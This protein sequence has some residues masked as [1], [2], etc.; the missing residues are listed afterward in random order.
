MERKLPYSSEAEEALIACLLIE[1]ELI[2][3]IDLRPEDFFG[4]KNQKIFRAI[5]D[6]KN[7]GITADQ[8]MVVDRL[9]ANGDY[10]SVGGIEFFAD[11]LLNVPFE[12]NIK[13]YEKVI[14]DNSLKRSL[15][16]TAS[17]I[18][19][20]CYSKKTTAEEAIAEAEKKIFEVSGLK[21]SD[22]TETENIGDVMYK[23][24]E[25]IYENS[26]NGNEITGLSTGFKKLDFK[27]SGLQRSDLII[28]AA[29]PSMGKTALAVNIAV[30]NALKENKSV[31]IFSL[32]MSKE[33]MALRMLQSEAMISAGKLKNGNIA[34]EDW[35]PIHHI[36]KELSKSHIKICDKA[37][38]SLSELVNRARKE[39]LKGDIDLIVID[40]LQLM[41]TDRKENR[42]SEISE[43]SRGLKQLA[44]EMDCPV[45]CLSQ[46]S[47]A[48]ETRFDKHPV[49]SD[50]R[51]SGSIE[52]DADVVLM[53][54]RASYYDEEKSDYQAELNIAKQRNGPTGTI[55]LGWIP[56]YTKFTETE[57]E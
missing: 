57:L 25:K 18:L 23:T 8:A 10:K 3:E 24:V 22:Q 40:Y 51:D 15:A 13:S 52:Q 43:I 9:K 20:S 17:D 38:I 36:S 5:L 49:L 55:T 32:E 39:K 53:L 47:R 7:S 1:P 54:Y 44:R 19:N 29:R 50:L 12:R 2:T 4:T 46:L 11:L 31:L 48:T 45:L 35:I 6:L 30:H 42:Q 41:S 28:L 56:E 14:K 26:V 37:G 16:V 27:L 33:Q 34:E 21:V